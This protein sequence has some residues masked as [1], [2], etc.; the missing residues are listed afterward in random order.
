MRTQAVGP[1]GDKD[2]DIDWGDL[3]LKVFNTD[4]TDSRFVY[5]GGSYSRLL[6]RIKKCKNI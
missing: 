4:L 2:I 5:I 6:P 1:L 3:K